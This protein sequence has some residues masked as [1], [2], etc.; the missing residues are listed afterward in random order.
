MLE[1]GTD[2]WQKEVVESSIPVLVDFWAPWCGPCRALTPI[3]DQLADE[4]AGKL[5]VGKVNID[6]NGDL[7]AQFG[8]NSIPRML[9]FK[10]GA[11]PVQ[12]VSRIAERGRTD[13]DAESVVG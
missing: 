1:F 7:A 3:V 6:E 11:N 9:V 10:G 2:N 5:K 13:A 8:I 4:F 12:S